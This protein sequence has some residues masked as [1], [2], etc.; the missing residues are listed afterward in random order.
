MLFAPPASAQCRRDLSLRDPSPSDDFPVLV[1][2][3]IISA[4]D[5]CHCPAKVI[6][7]CNG[8][9]IP[10]WNASAGQLP[11]EPDEDFILFT[12]ADGAAL[13]GNL[14]CSSQAYII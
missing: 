4:Q 14:S 7:N 10:I 8:V 3:V 2:L 5:F 1:Q 11:G 12:I 13:S 6:Q 9:V